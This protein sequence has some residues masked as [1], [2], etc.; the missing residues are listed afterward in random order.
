MSASTRPRGSAWYMP[1]GVTSMR[2]AADA[3]MADYHRR[4]FHQASPVKR[5]PAM[6]PAP[7][8]GGSSASTDRSDSVKTVV[9]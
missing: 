2:M 3:I 7:I 6:A 1:D 4:R 5:K 8:R 9:G